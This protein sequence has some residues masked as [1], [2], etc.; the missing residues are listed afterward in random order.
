MFSYKRIIVIG[1][2]GAGKSTFGRK[3]HDATQIDLYHLDAIYWNKDCSHITR[4]ELIEKQKEIFEKDSFIIDGNFKSTLELRI[5]EADVVFLFDL[6]TD[7]CIQG[8]KN[9]KGNRPEMP[10]QLP[11]NQELIDFIKSFNKDVMP[12]MKELFKKYN[13]NVITFH[14]HKEADEYI[15]RIKSK[16][17]DLTLKTELGYFNHRVA[18]VIIKDNHLLAQRNPIDNSYYLVGGRVTFGESAE[19]A[20][21]REIK[22]EL[23]IDINNYKTIWIN[24]C[25]FTENS[26][27]YHEI[28]MYYLVDISNTGFRHYEK[29][30]EIIEG[31]RTNNYEWLDIDKLSDI[32]L[33]PKFIKNEIK[34]KNKELK[35]IITRENKM[36]LWDAYNEQ[37]ELIKGV[38]FIRGNNIPDG[39]FHLVCNVAVKHIDGTYLIMQRDFK[40]HFGGMWELTAG[41]SAIQGEKPIECA[42][43]ELKEET[44]I[45]SNDLKELGTVVSYENKTI[46]CDF[47]CVTDCDKDSVT[48]QQGETVAYK[49]ISADEI[50]AL[51][52]ENLVTKRIPKSIF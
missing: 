3:L 22:E 39:M 35:L 28:G 49:W 9:R 15:E 38:T 24:E 19:D 2:P 43:R 10:C 50:K 11:D 29:S 27:Y 26:K 6:P 30:F 16:N 1:C 46:Y 13:S 34:T 4:E 23:K 8:A 40:K 41:G 48:L 44:G 17:I 42:I 36:E 12:R 18:A 14:S 20:L 33:Y 51:S 32:N 47:L 25:F 7:I 37:F 52:S 21:I 5:K 31:K 45:I